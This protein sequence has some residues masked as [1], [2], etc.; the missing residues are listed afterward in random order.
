MPM[1]NPPHIGSFIRTEVVEPFDLSVTDAAEI[2]GVTRQALNNLLNEKSAL[3]PEMA[4]RIEKAFGPKMDHLLRM[5]LAFDIAQA[6][7]RESRIK[8]RRVRRRPDP[9]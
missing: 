4:L 5:Q 2:L 1:K 8:V 6:R 9:D 3:T 7:R